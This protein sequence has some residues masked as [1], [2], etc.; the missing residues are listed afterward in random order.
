MEE[1]DRELRKVENV[2]KLLKEADRIGFDCPEITQLRERAEA[3]ANFQRDAKTLLDAPEVGTTQEFEDILDTGRGFNVDMPELEKLETIL[4]QKKWGDRA[5][6]AHG[7]YLALED[8]VSL[9]EDGEKLAIAES[10]Y[11]L[12]HFRKQK[13]AGEAWET[14]AKELMAVEIVHYP[15]LDALRNQAKAAT[16]PVSAETLERL[17]RF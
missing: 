8:V 11:F 3:I 15:Q 5:R 9:I 16:L 10:N 12:L 14:K 6:E 1:R 4:Q 17:T 2:V 13:E 7:Q